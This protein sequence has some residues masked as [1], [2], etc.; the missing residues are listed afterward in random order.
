MN[1]SYLELEHDSGTEVI[2]LE[3]D[4]LTL[5]RDRSNDVALPSDAAI[6]RRHAVLG[7]DTNAPIVHGH[8]T[9][10][11]SD[12]STSRVEV[13]G[14]QQQIEAAQWQAN[15]DAAQRSAEGLQKATAKT[16]GAINTGPAG[17]T[18]GGS[19][20]SGPRS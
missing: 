12:G 15:Y 6:S 2:G 11:N 9:V 17:N 19:P 1:G 3:R 10:T 7:Q 8:V 20:G 13:T 4:V 14:T 16:E 5:G 18:G